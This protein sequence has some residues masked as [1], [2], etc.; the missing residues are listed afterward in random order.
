MSELPAGPGWYE[1]EHD[2]L[3]LRYFDGV[4]WT[5]HTTT[6]RSPTADD[7]TIGRATPGVIPGRAG[8]PGAW[9]QPTQQGPGQ[10]QGGGMPPGGANPYQHGRS[11]P[12]G[13]V[14]AE[15]WR[16]LVGRILDIIVTVVITLVIAFPWVS[17]AV[18]T[19][20]DFFTKTMQAAENG[21]TAPSQTALTEQFFQVVLPITLISIVVSL[22]YETS[23]L[24]LRGAT[25]GKMVMGT[26]VRPVDGPGRISVITALRRQVI[27]VATSLMGLVPLLS[28][29]GSMLQILDPAWL[30]WDPKRQ[31][32]HDKLAETVVVLRN[33][34]R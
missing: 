24:T 8:N 18:S 10:W 32:L 20:S 2:P 31:C 7:S 23:F 25:P 27:A 5:S 12:D 3:L 15:W 6:R 13:D 11:L 17:K 26:V 29:F 28:V 21:T 4:V 16:R 14:L 33:P 19:M 22:V 1:D 34:Q 30:L 9:G